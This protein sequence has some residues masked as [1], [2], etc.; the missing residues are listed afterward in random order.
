MSDHRTIQHGCGNVSRR[1]FLS[2]TGLGFTDLA[3]NAM[4]FRDGIGRAVANETPWSPPNGMAHFA[5]RAKSVIWLFMLGG[6]SHMESFDPK[7]E[8]N[9]YAGKKFTETP[10]AGVVESPHLKE[11]LREII[12]GLH[13]SH[14]T[15]FPL[16]V[17]FRKRGESGIEVS[18]W[19]PHVGGCVDE[20]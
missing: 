14:T 18:D 6:T 3:L 5:P 17:G 8:L 4:L 10:Y 2:D 9:K 12:A 15:L 1:A 11:N 16:Q 7:P 13:K 19:W 20:M